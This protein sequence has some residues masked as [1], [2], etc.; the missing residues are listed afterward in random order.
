MAPR[1][2]QGNKRTGATRN[3][4]SGSSTLKRLIIVVLV[5]VFGAFLMYLDKMPIGDK[6]GAHTKEKAIKQE[7][8]QSSENKK[9]K[10]KFDF[11]TELS[12][13]EVETY[14]IEEEPAAAKKVI[15]KAVQKPANIEKK[16]ALKTNT[17]TAKP[18]AKYKPQSNM[19]Y[20]LQVGA[21]SEWSKADAMKGRLALLGVEAN[22]QVFQL[23]GQKMYRLRV[24]PTTDSQKIERIK[25]QLK[26]Q[27]INTFIQKI[28]L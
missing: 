12:D 1:K 15:A 3:T 17:K 8:Q 14:T 22:I 24:G 27:N 10:Y 19:L 20:Q 9:E 2:K 23:N 5:F 6:S 7:K 18:V 4:G 21:F 26:A 11:Y 25:V 13:R 16:P 28:K